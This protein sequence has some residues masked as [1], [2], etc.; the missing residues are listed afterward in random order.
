M[1][2]PI[3]YALYFVLQFT[4][5]TTAAV[6]QLTSS[7]S[8]SAYPAALSAIQL[9]SVSM[10][11]GSADCT[12]QQL[13]DVANVKLPAHQKCRGRLKG[14]NKSLNLRYGN[15][16]GQQ[17]KAT[18]RKLQG[19]DMVEDLQNSNDNCVECGRADDP[20]GQGKRRRK[21]VQWIQ[22]DQCNYWYHLIC[23]SLCA[24]PGDGEPFACKRCE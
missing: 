21:D 12:D 24:I 3:Y 17:G 22:C 19:K 9:R 2:H 4:P 1:P 8:S 14:T 6:S 18:K 20:V 11:N 13:L 5:S 15:K 7:A 23:T 10:H 16:G